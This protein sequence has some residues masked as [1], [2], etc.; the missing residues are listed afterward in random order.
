MDMR[1]KRQLLEEYKNRRPEM[2]I[3]SFCCKT[4]QEMFLCL[5]QDTKADINSTRFKLLANSHPNKRLQ[6]LW[7]QYGESDFDITLMK[8]FKY[9]SPHDDHRDKLEK[10][11]TECLEENAGAKRVWK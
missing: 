2:G 5:S 11:L 4:T 9:E 1:R 3:L 10:Q 7:N 6:T 8:A